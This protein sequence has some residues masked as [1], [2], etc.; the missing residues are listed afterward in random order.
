MRR[1]RGALLA[2]LAAAALALLPAACAPAATE[3]D[4]D[5]SLVLHVEVRNNYSTAVSRD[6]YVAGLGGSARRIGQVPAAATRRLD[7][8]SFDWQS[9]HVLRAESLTGEVIESAPFFVSPGGRVVWDLSRNRIEV[10]EP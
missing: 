2:A 7:A 10:I 6:V 9:Q 3:G 8:R 5:G 4:G 1:A